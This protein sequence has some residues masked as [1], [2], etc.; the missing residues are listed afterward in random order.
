MKNV[1]SFLVTSQVSFRDVFI[2][3]TLLMKDR[4]LRS[5]VDPNSS[6]KHFKVNDTET[7]VNQKAF[8]CYLMINNTIA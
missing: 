4:I 1:R 3:R 8:I 5:F 6:D 2:S 7:I